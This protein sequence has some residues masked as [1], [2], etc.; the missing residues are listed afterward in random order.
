MALE[1]QKAFA[2]FSGRTND[3][4]GSIAEAQPLQA[5]G[6]GS[7][8]FA[9]VADSFQMSFSQRMMAFGLTF[10][11]GIFFLFMS[12][13]YVFGLVLGQ[14]TKF[15]LS[16]SLGNFLL[17]FST[18][19]LT[20]PQ[21]QWENITSKGRLASSSLW[22]GSMFGTLFSAFQ[23]PYFYILLPLIVIQIIALVSYILTYLP[24]GNFSLVGSLF[25]RGRSLLP[26]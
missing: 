11:G 13:F 7:G 9:S 21:K 22:I 8:V 5:P 20:G 19:F 2:E 24:F 23:Y 6:A 17:F 12:S 4:S 14:T 1:F 26:I 3:L 25:N 15:A 10:V 18:I 16:Y